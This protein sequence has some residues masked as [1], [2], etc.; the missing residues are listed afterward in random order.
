M[1]LRIPR[2]R[3]DPPLLVKSTP[4]TQLSGEG[5]GPRGVILVVHTLPFHRIL[6]LCDL[7]AS[8]KE[9][10]QVGCINNSVTC[11]RLDG[12][13]V[14]T[15]GPGVL[16]NRSLTMPRVRTPCATSCRHGPQVHCLRVEVQSCLRWALVGR[17]SFLRL[18]VDREATVSTLVDVSC[19]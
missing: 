10:S 8:C 11:Q 19:R 7:G 2:E 5:F 4:K 3:G 1:V 15:V 16:V 18:A 13:E 12:V 14:A 17:P 9:Q 6:E